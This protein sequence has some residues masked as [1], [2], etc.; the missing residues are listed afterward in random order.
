[1]KRAILL[2]A[3]FVLIL[4]ACSGN[5]NG[6]GTSNGESALPGPSITTDNTPDAEEAA[7]AYLNAWQE[8]D[9]AA[10]YAMLSTLSQD[11]FS[12]EEFEARYE[13]VSR[14]A[15]L[16]NIEYEILQSLTNPNSAQVAYRLILHSAIIG[17]ITRETMMNLSLEGK[18]WRVGWDDTLIL[19]ELE[20]GNTLSMERFDPARGNIY[21]NEGSALAVNTSAVA[22]GVIP[23]QILEEEANL[24][25]SS[26]SNLTGVPV[27]TL[28]KEIFPEDRQAPFY[29][30]VGEV[31]ADVFAPREIVFQ[32]F[33]EYPIVITI[34]VFILMAA[35]RR[36]LLVM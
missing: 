12:F 13:H 30:G 10:M 16:F 21:D 23:E 36:N 20:G 26:L 5:S 34:H 11:A 31:P 6:E 9:L 8:N 2:S 19:P 24:L 27:S 35:P 4:G 33:L 18:E 1:M 25:I 15:N 17:P 3:L 29:V 32:A 14:E 7:E 28:N 22:I